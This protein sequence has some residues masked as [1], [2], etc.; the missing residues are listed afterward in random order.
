MLEL[1][2]LFFASRYIIRLAKEKAEPVGKWLFFLLIGWLG[3]EIVGGVLGIFLLGIEDLTKPEHLIPV[4][5]FAIFGGII[6]F[7]VVRAQLLA[8]EP[9]EPET[10][11]EKD[12][13]YFR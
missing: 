11:P 13:S 4:L 8:I 7:L 2:V 12:L 6:G 9:E 5:P 10:P 1:I 3:G